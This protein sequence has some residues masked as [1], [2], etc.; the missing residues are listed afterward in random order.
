MKRCICMIAVGMMLMMGHGQA[1]AQEK[2]PAGYKDP[3]AAVAWGY[4]LPGAGHIYAGESVKGL[5]VMATSIGALTAGT[6]ATLNSGDENA[7]VGD[8]F[9][10]SVGA[11]DW[12]PFYIGGGVYALG[13]IYSVIDGAKA[14]ERSNKKNGLSLRSV[15]LDPYVAETKSGSHGFGVQLVVRL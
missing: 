12:T 8:D 1:V 4:L 14:A 5:V 9:D 15:R 11:T 10:F 7:E 6:I 13:W 3:K 2:K